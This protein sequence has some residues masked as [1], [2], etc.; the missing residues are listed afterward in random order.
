MKFLKIIVPCIVIFTSFNTLAQG[1]PSEL[2]FVLGDSNLKEERNLENGLYTIYV[3]I[4][5]TEA[6]SIEVEK[7]ESF[8]EEGPIEN[9]ES[10]SANFNKNDLV[11]KF[12][13]TISNRKKVNI[14][15]KKHYTVEDSIKKVSKIDLNFKSIKKHKW[16]TTYGVSGIYH[17][18]SDTYKTVQNGTNFMIT[19]D[20]SQGL[21]SPVPLIMFSY[22]NLEKP[23]SLAWSGG[24]G[25]DTQNIS[26]FFGPSYVIGQN[27]IFTAGV[28]LHKQKRLD[29]KYDVGQIVDAAIDSNDLNTEYF[30][31]NPFVSLTFNLSN[32]P[33][34][35]SSSGNEETSDQ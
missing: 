28:A 10:I 11:K 35:S 8:V 29:N 9:P 15:I 7:S 21:V 34:K 3:K 23:S 14:K 2:S 19:E 32:N 26:L 22:I 24:L 33:F 6:D 20:G 4:V 18:N 16:Q 27:L 5:G 25:F 1:N 12:S 13:F 31:V 17:V 30:R